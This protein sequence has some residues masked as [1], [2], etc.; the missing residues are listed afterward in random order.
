MEIVSHVKRSKIIVVQQVH[1]LPHV[2][3]A[4][5]IAPPMG[6]QFPT[7]FVHSRQNYADVSKIEK[8]LNVEL[9]LDS[10]SCL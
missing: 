1:V 5:R 6:N 2:V 9:D 8:K 4:L 3:I 7:D 10:C